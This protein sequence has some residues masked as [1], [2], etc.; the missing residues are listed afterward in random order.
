MPLPRAVGSPDGRHRLPD[1]GKTGAPGDQ[2]REV[3]GD[4]MRICRQPGDADTVGPGH[5]PCPLDRVDSSGDI[6]SAGRDGICDGW[7]ETGRM[8]RR[9]RQ[10]KDLRHRLR[11]YRLQVS[12]G[13]IGPRSSR[14]SWP[15]KTDWGMELTLHLENIR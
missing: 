5:E 6:G 1:R 3:L 8:L 12:S 9:D 14:E 15:G 4:I 7:G 13:L 10:E 2:V 11:E